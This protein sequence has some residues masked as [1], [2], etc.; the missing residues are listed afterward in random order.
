MSSNQRSCC[1]TNSEQWFWFMHSSWSG[2]YAVI[3]SGI[4]QMDY[5]LPVSSKKVL[6]HVA[7]VTFQLLY[8]FLPFGAPTILQWRRFRIH[9][10]SYSRVK[11]NCGHCLP[12]CVGNQGIHK[13]RGLS[14][15]L[16]VIWKTCLLSGWQTTTHKIDQL[17]FDLY[18]TWKIFPITNMKLSP[19]IAMFGTEEKVRLTSSSLPSEIINKLQTEDDLLAVLNTPPE[20]PEQQSSGNYHSDT[21]PDGQHGGKKLFLKILEIS[22]QICHPFWLVSTI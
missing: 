17:V 10:N 22:S 3:T 2:R 9:S 6:H 12:L 8:V 7:E 11:K 15:E 14:S 21:P 5:S 20:A 16:I 4:L 19:Y 1:D 13:A 18:K